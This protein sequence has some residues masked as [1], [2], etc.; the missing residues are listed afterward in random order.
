MFPATAL[1]PRRWRRGRRLRSGWRRRGRCL[2]LLRSLMLFRRFRAEAIFGGHLFLC[3]GGRHFGHYL[4]PVTTAGRKA[5]SNEERGAGQNRSFYRHGCMVD[6]GRLPT[7]SAD[8]K[9]EKEA[10]ARKSEPPLA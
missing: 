9:Q 8:C 2:L 4:L 7:R 6:A 10:A 3:W 5:E 1:L